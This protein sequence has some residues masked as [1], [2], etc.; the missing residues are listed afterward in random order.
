MAQKTVI[1]QDQIFYRTDKDVVEQEVEFREWDER[2]RD[3][4]RSD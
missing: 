3:L 2:F 1:G 4:E